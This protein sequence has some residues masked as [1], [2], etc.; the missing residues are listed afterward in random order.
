MKKQ[1]LI[2]L[3]A[4]AWGCALVI[5]F[6][7]RQA[8]ALKAAEPRSEMFRAR[9]QPRES[10]DSTKISKPEISNSGVLIPTQ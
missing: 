7:G 6:N 10:A 4:L 2:W 5:L 8:H 9:K 1:G 3:V